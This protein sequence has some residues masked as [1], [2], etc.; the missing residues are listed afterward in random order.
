MKEYRLER[1]GEPCVAFEGELIAQSD[2][3]WAAAIAVVM[4]AAQTR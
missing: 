2:G 3:Q 4:P 1:T